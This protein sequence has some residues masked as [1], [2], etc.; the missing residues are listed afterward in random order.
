M[1][2]ECDLAIDQGSRCAVVLDETGNFLSVTKETGSKMRVRGNRHETV[3]LKLAAIR[4]GN[5]Q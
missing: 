4:P 2:D 1:V 5:G 3:H